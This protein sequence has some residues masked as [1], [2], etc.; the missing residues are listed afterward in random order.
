MSPR[1]VRHWAG[2]TECRIVGQQLASVGVKDMASKTPTLQLAT[3]AVGARQVG[4]DDVRI[5]DP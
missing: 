4:V 2:N 1:M 5:R 3:L